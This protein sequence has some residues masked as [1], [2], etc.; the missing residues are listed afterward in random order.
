MRRARGFSFIE[1]LVVMGILALLVGLTVGIYGIFAKKGPEAT[2]D[3]LL[4]SLRASIDAWRGQ[5]KAY[6]PSQLDRIP[7]VTA[8]PVKVGKPVPPNQVNAGVESLY[9]CLVM[10]GF[11]HPFEAT[12]SQ[13]CNTDEEGGDRLDKPLAK[14]G[15][16]DLFELKDGWGNPIVYFVE[17]DYA[18]AD[19]AGNQP[20]YV[21][22]QG[23][24]VNPRP[25]RAESG[26]FAQPASYQLF[27]MGPDGIPNTEDDR[28]AW[29][30]R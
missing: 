16:P 6:P 4:Q 14:S 25:H 21:N 13:L 29:E 26:A 27:S 19:R 24:A 7:L 11:A 17:P 10:T 2:T 9:Q 12:D 8:L 18:E 1:V 5:F 28:V 23:E 22:G 20:T 30:A 15:V 3:H